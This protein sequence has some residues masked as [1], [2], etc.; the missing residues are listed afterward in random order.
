M[1]NKCFQEVN[2]F[3][4]LVETGDLKICFMKYNSKA[5]QGTKYDYKSVQEA[6][7]DPTRNLGIVFPGEQDLGHEKWVG[8]DIDGQDSVAGTQDPL[9]KVATRKYLFDC[10]KHG[11]K[12]RNI[13]FVCIKTIN[14]GFHI[15]FKTLE[16]EYNDHITKSLVYPKHQESF[17]SISPDIFEEFPIITAVANHPL[18][19]MAIEIFTK[20]KM[21]V[22][23]GSTIDG[24]K[25][26]LLPDGVQDFRDVT[27]YKDGSVEQLVMDILQY[28]CHFTF[29][30]DKV[31]HHNSQSSNIEILDHKKQLSSHNIK[32]I[33]NMMIDAFQHISGQKH[34]ATLALGGFLYSR[35]ISIDSIRA[36]G[37]YIVIHAP[38]NLFKNS[39]DVE[40][41][42]GFVQVLVHDSIENTEKAKTGLNTLREIFTDTDVHVG[43]ILRTLWNHTLPDSHIFEPNGKQ[44]KVY[45]EII[46]NFKDK[47]TL[48]CTKKDVKEDENEYSVIIDS[49]I[50]EH[51]LTDMN[52]IDDI[53]ASRVDKIEN[54]AI[55]FKLE[56]RFMNDVLYIFPNTD[57]MIKKYESLPLAHQEGAKKIMAFVIDE[58]EKIGIIGEIERSA[59]PGIYLSRDGTE[60]RRFIQK[61]SEIVECDAIPPDKEQLC[62][63]LSLLKQINDAYPW[64]DDK[65][66][67][68]VKLGMILPYGYVF[69]TQFNSFIRGIILYGEGGTCK[70]SA[71]ELIIRMNVPKSSID[72]KELD[73]IVPGSEFSTVYRMGRVLDAHS[74]PVMIEEVEGVFEEKDNRDLI[75]NSITRRFI[76]SPKGDKE[77]YSRAIPVFSANE[78]NDEIEKSGMFRRFLILNFVNGE[79][80]DKK[81]VEDALAF[82]NRNG[83]RNSRFDEL[84]VISEFIF[85]DLHNHLEY[86]S[87]NPQAI[88]DQV[89]QDMSSYTKMDLTWLLEPN[90]DKYYQSDRSE[91]DQSDL[92]MVL[93]TLKYHYKNSIKLSGL[94]SNVDEIFLER[95]IEDKYSY[96]YRIENRQTNGVL[97]TSDFNKSYKKSYPSAKKLNLDRLA[98]LLNENLDLEHTIEKAKMRPQGLKKRIQGIFIH[99]DDFCNIFNIKT[100]G[101]EPD[102]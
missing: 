30:P 102:E 72:E 81:E 23:P 74:Y 21:T 6:N 42:S 96:I 87:K 41:S 62:A 79:R 94:G 44:G 76:R 10:L 9:L 99:W 43:D 57:E 75:K 11:L 53:S 12:S 83:R 97:I 28:D 22:A 16:S 101:E 78:L 40:L 36:L 93:D 64:Y 5:P 56:S 71:S 46:L 34:Y 4:E 35:N 61:N 13:D 45:P 92:S 60:L 47:K 39:K 32:S 2:G 8:I 25:Y 18:T 38:D 37:E 84:Y 7:S 15:Y 89:I 90:F 52:Y 66:A 73:Y 48:Y 82:L 98:E 54:K 63:A 55:S 77:Y 100:G 26:T 31:R 20:G 3:E 68:F 24:K 51:V 91:E 95:L 29:N 17:L 88:I 33:G 50:I 59:I 86:F 69:K 19:T 85:Y 80:G 49:K 70:S 1:K 65:F 27:V 67:T 14:N 58:F